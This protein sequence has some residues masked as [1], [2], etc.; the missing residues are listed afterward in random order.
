MSFLLNFFLFSDWDV[1]PPAGHFLTAPLA[2]LS[3]DSSWTVSVSR[4]QTT[5][6]MASCPQRCT[7]HIYNMRE[8]DIS[9]VLSRG[10]G[11]KFKLLCES[12]AKMN[13]SPAKL[14]V[15]SSSQVNL[16]V[17]G[18]PAHVGRCRL[19]LNWP[20]KKRTAT[21]ASHCPVVDVLCSG[22]CANLKKKIITYKSLRNLSTS[23]VVE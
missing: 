23:R 16:T 18:S 6:R 21:E 9:A 17:S 20:S 2:D 11:S 4:L 15:L 1:W 12:D 7:W 10:F 5:P 19:V 14:A 3:P 8:L 22:L 13:L